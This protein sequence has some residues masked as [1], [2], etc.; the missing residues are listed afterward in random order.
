VAEAAR[1]PFWSTGA[2]ALGQSGPG[3][4]RELFNWADASATGE[5]WA[6]F[7]QW[8]GLEQGFSDSAASFWARLGSRTQGPSYLASASAWAGYVE[9]LAFFEPDG[10]AADLAALP[11]AKLFDVVNVAVFRSPLNATQQNFLSLKGGN[12]GWNHGHLD[13]G[14]F[15][16]DYA[17]RRLAEDLGADSYN[18]PG[19]FGPQRFSYYRLNSLGHNVCIFANASQTHP[20]AAPITAFAFTG[21]PAA[22]G[23]I[24]LDGYAIVDLTAAYALPAG[25]TSA[26]RGF[27]SLSASAAVV[28]VDEFVYAAADG[29]G[30]A[31]AGLEGAG[32][33]GAEGAGAPVRPANLTWQLHTRAVA[34]QVSRTE[35]SLQ[36]PNGFG[37]GANDAWLALLPPPQPTSCFGAFGGFVFTDLTTVLPDPPFDS[38]AGLTRVDIVFGGPSPQCASVAVALGDSPIVAALSMGAVR[39]RPMAEWETD[40]PLDVS[41]VGEG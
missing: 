40:G 17:G 2:N 18:L 8:W 30:A 20:V 29:A 6:P 27:V 5:D 28:V 22:Q 15:V 41:G 23:N 14:S 7:A 35:V 34:T 19:Y 4:P 10:S 11:T 9:A 39:V 32:A 24:S 26:R 36:P 37:P 33:L 31:G 21:A 13:L 38:A 3:F 16:F 25:V 1:F 12:S